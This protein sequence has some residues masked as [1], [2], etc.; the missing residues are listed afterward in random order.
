MVEV[1]FLDVGQGDSSLIK[2]PNG[3]TMLID[4]K[5]NDDY[6]KQLDTHLLQDE[7]GKK[8]IDY[9]VI[10][11][12]HQDHIQG[13][14]ELG[15][16]YLI[17]N[18][19]ESGHRLYVEKEK[20]D[21]YKHYYDMLDLI[22]KVKRKDGQYKELKAYKKL[23]IKNQPDVSF[24]VL[25]PTKA[26]LA[27]EKPT[28]RDIHDQCLVLKMDYKNRSIVFSGDS[29]MEAWKERIV[30]YYSDESGR[31]NLLD[32]TILHA[33]HHGSYTFFKPKG[34][35][36]DE[37]YIEG[38]KKIN[39]EITILSVGKN[40]NHDHPDKEALELYKKYTENEQVYE[41]MKHGTLNVGIEDTGDY[42]IITEKMKKS[43]KKNT[44][45]KVEIK[46]NPTP[47]DGEF[48]EKNVELYFNAR[49]SNIPSNQSIKSITWIVQNNATGD[50]THHD[51]YIGKIDKSR[52]YKNKTKYS[53]FHILL[54]E[55]RNQRGRV[56]ATDYLIVKVKN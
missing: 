27:D 49:V 54:C 8:I 31:S 20:Q 21:Q 37:P 34:K 12:P 30:P 56:I 26:F 4:C 19:W 33:S 5:V 2:F 38:L 39:P 43:M 17:K 50:D 36:D 3:T 7:D 44:L 48:Y 46:V 47:S 45:A 35:K 11:H 52:N 29:S 13:I 53:G 28:K 41:T 42:H 10:T 23:S 9:L 55:V 14:G 6:F 1:Y 16:K 22:Q 40:N 18:I 51:W 25:S 15:K 32:S 24:T